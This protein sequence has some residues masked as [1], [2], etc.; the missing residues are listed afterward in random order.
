M[1]LAHTTK[2]ETVEEINCATNWPYKLLLLE[3]NEIE[4]ESSHWFLW[5][6]FYSY[7]CRGAA[8]NKAYLK[9]IGITHVLNCAEGKFIMSIYRYIFVV[10]ITAQYLLCTFVTNATSTHR[11]DSL[12]VYILFR[13]AEIIMY[14][15]LDLIQL[16]IWQSIIILLIYLSNY[17]ALNIL[18]FHLSLNVLSMI[19]VYTS[20]K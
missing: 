8:K 17:W 20:V 4:C 11:D 14:P 2:N 7:H 19:Q 5:F 16:N 9:L 3:K 12:N 1:Q 18:F 13:Q 10:I 6:S 15:W